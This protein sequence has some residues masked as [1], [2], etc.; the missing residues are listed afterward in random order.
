MPNPFVMKFLKSYKI[1]GKNTFDALQEELEDWYTFEDFGEMLK[2]EQNRSDRTGLPFSFVQIEI[3]RPPA[4]AHLLDDTAYEDFLRRLLKLISENTRNYDVKFLTPS[5]TVGILLIDTSLEGAR[6]FIEKISYSLYK[7]FQN[8]GKSD[9]LKALQTI[10]I[11]SYPLSRLLESEE[12]RPLPMILRS[13]KFHPNGGK[14]PS[15]QTLYLENERWQLNWERLPVNGNTLALDLN[16]MWQSMCEDRAHLR[17]HLVKRIIDILGA[18]LGLLLFSPAM[19]VIALFI[20]L[21]SPGPVF[22]VQKRIG[23]FQQPFQFYKFRTMYVDADNEIHKQ[24]VQ[25]LISGKAANQGT[26][27]KPLYKLNNDPRITW[28]GRYLRLFSMDELPQLFNVLKGD[29]SLVGPRP[30]IDYEIE[31]YQSWHLRRIFEAKPGITGLWQVYGR[32]KTTFDEMVRLDLQ[33]IA[34]RSIFLDIKTILLTFRAILKID[35]AR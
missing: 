20:K 9:Y 29:M 3:A 14:D 11:S 32:S 19:G 4:V 28:I 35:E 17:Y 22:Y 33:Y 34:N 25:Q 26:R 7:Y 27:D 2:K 21:T 31:K 30:P 15:D 13:Q 24:F 6:G 18:C 8:M 1:Y 12:E 23:Q 16:Y 10:T 5:F